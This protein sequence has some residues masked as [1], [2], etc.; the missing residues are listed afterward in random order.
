MFIYIILLLPP[1]GWLSECSGGVTG[2]G[3]AAVTTAP[4][5]P[6]IISRFP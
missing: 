3:G 1:G 6:A 2:I 4:T 5:A